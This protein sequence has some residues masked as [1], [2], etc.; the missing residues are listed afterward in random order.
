MDNSCVKYGVAVMRFCRRCLT[1]IDTIHEMRENDKQ[2]FMQTMVVGEDYTQFVERTKGIDKKFVCEE[3]QDLIRA[4]E[5]N[6]SLLFL[7]KI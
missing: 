4:A 2:H 5:D 7:W 6:L 3:K 1:T